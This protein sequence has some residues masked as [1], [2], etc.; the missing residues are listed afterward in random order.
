M[1]RGDLTDQQWEQLEPLL[2]ASKGKR[3][4]QW[5]C[6]RTVINGIRWVLRTGAPWADLPARYGPHWS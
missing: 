1:A 2:P 5:K 6:H 3:G 4:G